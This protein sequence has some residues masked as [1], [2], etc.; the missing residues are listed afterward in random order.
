MKINSAAVLDAI[1]AM[2]GNFAEGRRPATKMLSGIEVAPFRDNADAASCISADFEMGWGWRSRG[3]DG[4]TLM[5]DRERRHVPLIVALLEEYSVPVTWATI[6]HLF[7]ESCTRSSAGLA[8]PT[9]PRPLSDGTWTGDWYWPDPCS[10]V[11]D[12]PAWYGPDLIQQIIESNVPHEIGTHSFSHINFQA[13]YSSPDVVLGELDSCIDAMRPFGVK[14]RTLIFP[15]HQAEYSYLPLL[16]SAGVIAIRHRD[17]RVRLSYPERM[18]SG[19][20]RIYES[21]NLRIAKHYDYLEKA[22]IFIGKAMERRAAY[23]LW[24]H[25]SDP[26]DWFDPQLR[27]ILQYMAAERRRGRLWITTMQELAAYCEARDQLKLS[28]ERDENSVTIAIE[29]SLDTSRYG[30]A[31]VTLLIPVPSKPKFGWLG[32]ASGEKTDADTRM[33]CDGSARAMINVPTTATA[34]HLAL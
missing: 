29:R 10:N 25:P 28:V 17:T 20:Y 6:G 21:M 16:A 12:A 11:R 18:A 4:A 1:F 26:A 34:L 31:E 24:F 32:F 3:L 8:H 13:P 5:G 14:P 33:A 15:R 30:A 23:A 19:V 27:A 9:M 2:K 7:L 22:K